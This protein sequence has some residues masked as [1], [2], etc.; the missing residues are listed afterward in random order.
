[1]PK[2]ITPEYLARSGTEHGE[3]MAVFCWASLNRERFP[4][5]RWMFAIPNGGGRGMAQGAAFKAEGVKAGVSD[6]CLPVPNREGSNGLFI[7]MKRADG[8][9]GDVKKEQ[10]DFIVF[11]RSQGYRAE[12]AF[13]WQQAV[14]IIEEYLT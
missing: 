5:L 4:V 2:Q 11:V 7:E 13:G 9:Q 12:V 6:I 3:Q 1:M 8:K 10:T 14:K